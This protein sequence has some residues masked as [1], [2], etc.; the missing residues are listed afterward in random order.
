M[1]LDFFCWIFLKGYSPS[2]MLFGNPKKKFYKG[3][4]QL[5]WAFLGHIENFQPYLSQ[6]T[7]FWAI[8]PML[9]H[10]LLLVAQMAQKILKKITSWA[11]NFFWWLNGTMRLLKITSNKTQKR[12]KVGPS[13]FSW[14]PNFGSFLSHFY[15]KFLLGNSIF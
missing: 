12:P 6:S 1:R 14:W 13:I 11:T 9:S 15:S 10:Q 5:F 8:G 7:H 2:Y 4:A 3:K